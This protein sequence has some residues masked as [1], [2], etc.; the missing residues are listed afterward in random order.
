M[1]KYFY[2]ISKLFFSSIII[3]SSL[4]CQNNLS[5]INGEVKLSNLVSESSGL[6]V[7]SA[8]EGFWTINDAGN[9]NELF[10]FDKQ[11]KIKQVV[12]VFNAKNKDWEALA[13]D[14]NSM[15]YIGDFGNNNN[16]R[17]DLTIYS[18][19]VNTIKDDKV[20]AD[21]ITFTYEDQSE[22]PPKKKDRN[23]DAEAFIFFNDYFYI[24][25]KNRSSNFDGTTKLYKVSAELGEK[26][27]RLIGK[28]ITC[29]NVKNCQ[30][31]GA[32]ISDDGKHLALLT[33]NSVY[34]FSDYKDDNFFSG[35]N[36]KIELNHNSQKEAI[37][38]VGNTLYITDEG[39][40]KSKC[41]MYKLDV[42]LED[43]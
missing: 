31:T 36:K 37:C 18:V 15:L 26:K 7:L 22:F 27:A 34:L 21:K 35:K 5:E 28:F 3:V 1:L 39:T 30:I 32:D 20:K 43:F 14:G 23:F 9:T 40:K 2:R 19:D 13:S 17:K 24:F 8:K 10:L 4:N 25:S 11:G 33:H 12:E 38:F 6:E 42:E 29:D 41:K 16:S